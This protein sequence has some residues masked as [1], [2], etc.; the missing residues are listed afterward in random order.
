[1]RRRSASTR[2]VVALVVGLGVAFGATGAVGSAATA[3]S[4]PGQALQDAV[5]E[6]QSANR[7]PG[8]VGLVRDG[9]TVEEAHAGVGDVFQQ[10]P[11]DPRAQ[12]RIGSNTKAFVST[13]V[14]QLVG[15]GRIS[16]D[17]TVDHWLPGV[18]NKNG[19]D[20]TKITI[21]QLLNHTSG[22]PEYLA[23]AL[24]L[25][26]GANL[27]PAKQWAPQQLVDAA[28]ASAP[29]FEPGTAWGYS[30]TNYVLAGMLITAVTGKAPADEVTARIIQPLGLNDTTYPTEPEVS[31]NYLHGYHS[32]FGLNRD[33]TV[34]NVGVT[35][36]AGAMV[37]TAADLSTFTRA[38]FSGSLLSPEQQQE[39]ETTVPT[40]PDGTGYDYG[41][42]VGRIQTPC[43]P[44]WA[45][46]GALL[47]YL[48][49]WLSDQDGTR[50]V[51][52]ATNQF[53]ATSANTTKDLGDAA[54]AGFCA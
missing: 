22:I 40:A 41:L 44:A 38:L 10:T 6:T 37:S 3:A 30:N 9:D 26:Y 1:M 43:G 39:L 27:N 29:T 31:G 33:V 18:V 5:R 24:Q 54:A 4:S 35:G 25:E 48:S 13:V 15:E 2:L 34:S 53:P 20:G 49:T 45:H 46:S 32:I 50:V 21:R 14:L 36:P 7:L 23:G 47:G 11:A 42:G 8:V 52:A 28:T 19:N 51:V 17:D 12:F 16:L